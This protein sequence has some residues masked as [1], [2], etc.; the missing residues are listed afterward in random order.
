[1]GNDA[2][3]LSAEMVLD[4]Q[5]YL[6]NFLNKLITE[7]RYL[8]VEEGERE[9]FYKHTLRATLGFGMEQEYLSNWKIENETHKIRFKTRWRFAKKMAY[10]SKGDKLVLDTA[11]RTVLDADPAYFW[12]HLLSMFTDVFP[13]AVKQAFLNSPE[14]EKREGKSFGNPRD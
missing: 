3:R 4:H 12:K 7:N 11:E 6:R 8:D 14:R 1:M 13:V 10:M 5:K 2:V 9:K